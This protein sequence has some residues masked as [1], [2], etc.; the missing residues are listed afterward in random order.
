MNEGMC[1]RARLSS[2]CCP[3][4]LRRRGLAWNACDGRRVLPSV[5]SPGCSVRNGGG[6]KAVI[7]SW[8]FAVSRCAT[9]EHVASAAGPCRRWCAAVSSHQR[10]KQ[11]Q[12]AGNE[13]S[14]M[15]VVSCARR[16]RAGGV[17]PF[18]RQ[19]GMQ[20]YTCGILGWRQLV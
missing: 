16:R 14:M 9:C 3:A 8:C 7:G 15:V 17:A 19:G 1:C 5:S 20:C 6:Q 12:A 13:V 2:I 4:K 18:L 11:R 10:W